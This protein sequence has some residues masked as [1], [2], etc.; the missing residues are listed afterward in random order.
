MF[1][2]AHLRRVAWPSRGTTL[3]KDEIMIFLYKRI[4]T[5]ERRSAPDINWY[6]Y[7][8]PYQ[9]QT[10]HCN[11]IRH[12]ALRY[13]YIEALVLK[14]HFAQIHLHGCF[15]VEKYLT[16]TA[17]HWPTYELRKNSP[18]TSKGDSCDKFS[19]LG[20]SELTS[21]RGLSALQQTV[22]QSTDETSRY[23]RRDL[24]ILLSKPIWQMISSHIGLISIL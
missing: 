7:G 6:R 5:R 1:K 19:R 8:C 11:I 15:T 18:T 21:S 12:T 22:D 17:L 3:V 23:I 4:G 9:L 16:D 2:W 14:A 24:L 10:P 20:L 13:C